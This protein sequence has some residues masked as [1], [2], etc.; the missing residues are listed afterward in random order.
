[1]QE[2]IVCVGAGGAGLSNIVGILRD[3]GFKNIIGIDEQASQITQ[4]L[5]NKGIQIFAH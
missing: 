3:L 1:M 5:Q 4:Q 2:T